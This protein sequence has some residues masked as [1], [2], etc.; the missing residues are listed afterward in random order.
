MKNTIQITTRR[1]VDAYLAGWVDYDFGPPSWGD[2][3]GLCDYV[4]RFIDTPGFGRAVNG[5]YLIDAAELDR[6][7]H[8]YADDTDF[9]R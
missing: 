4:W 2:F 6:L 8:Q 9:S 1:D 3:D 7:A 5:S